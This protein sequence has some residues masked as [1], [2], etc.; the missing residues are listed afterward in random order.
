[1]H[2]VVLQEHCPAVHCSPGPHAAHACPPLPQAETVVVVTHTPFA[3]QHP[4][5]QVVDEQA[6]VPPPW[7]PAPAEPPAPTAPPMPP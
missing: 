5:G 3:S 4:V 6:G 7:P 1:V 2:E